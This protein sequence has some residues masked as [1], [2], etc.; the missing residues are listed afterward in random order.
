M[1]QSSRKILAVVVALAGLVY[2]FNPTAGV[3]EF[4]PDNLPFIGNID[5]GLA[6]YLILAAVHL[7]RTGEFNLLSSLTRRGK[8]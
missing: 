6:A 5:E 4:L 2:L 3:F 7:F 1:N 8:S